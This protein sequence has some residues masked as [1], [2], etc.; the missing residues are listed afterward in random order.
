MKKFVYLNITKFIALLLIFHGSAARADLSL[1]D[2]L[3]IH[4]FLTQAFFHSS[5]NNFYGQSDDDVSPGLTE[6]GLNAAYQLLPRLRF[7]AQGLYR[8]AGDLDH[9]SVRLDYGLADLTLLSYD[10]G[11]VGI[12]AGR[13]KV[14]YGL[15]NETRDVSFTHPTVTLPQG[16]YFDQ[17][18]SLMLSADGGS[19]YAD[20]RVPFGDLHFKFNY[21][22]A[23]DDNQEVKTATLGLGARG[24]LKARPA[25]ATQLAYEI[26]GGEYIVAVSYLDLTLDYQPM[27]GE[28]LLAGNT[29]L[30]PLLFSA[31]YNGEKLTLTAEY[32]YRWYTMTGYGRDFQLQAQSWYVQGS[33]QLLSKLQATVRYDVFDIKTSGIKQA[34]ILAAAANQS[35]YAHDWMT[36]LR[37]DISSSWMVRAEYHRINGTAW[38]PYADNHDRSQLT[39]NWDLYALQLSF[40][41]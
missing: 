28:Q 41:F 8:R 33:Y 7:A 22:L 19:F 27:P 18:R 35:P 17:S 3:Q 4:G 31:Q 25:L 14:P 23:L 12:R 10:S 36:G 21:G 9:G 26:N 40:R 38:L 1:P 24:M 15:Y 13:V 32:D 37:W 16:I 29:H 11:R 20:Q 34:D 39:S 2:D 6:I 5:D 30:Q